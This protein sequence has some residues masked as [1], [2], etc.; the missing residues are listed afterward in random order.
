MGELLYRVSGPDDL[1]SLTMPELAELASEIREKIISVVSSTGG[2]LAPSLGAVELAIAIH[3]V[4]DSPRDRI[5]W[6]VGHQAYA[7]KLLTGRRERFQTLRQEG[8]LSGFPRLSESEHDAFGTGH[9]STSISAALGMSCARDAMGEDFHVVAVIGDGAL[10]GGLSFEGLNQAGGLG[11]RLIV[12]INDNKMSIS[13]NVGALAKYMTRLIAGPTYRK[14]EA[15]LWELLGRT[16]Y[17]GRTAR[18]V[19]GRVTESLKGFIVP[20]TIFEELGFKYYGPIDGHALPDLISVLKQ[21][22][23]VRVPV[24][25]H[26]L[27]T[28][29]KGYRFAEQN[30]SQFHG[31]GA[32]DK[33]TGTEEKKPGFP[34]YTD[35]FGSWMV[36][37]GERFGSVVAVTAAMKDNTGLARFAERFP[38]RFFDV[39]MAEGH[40]VTFAAGLATRGLLPVVAIYSTFLQRAFDH[41]VHDVAL[42]KLKV[43]FA[44]DRAGL[45][46]QDG[47]THHGCLDLVYL[48]AVPG[49]T[50]MA[51]VN[52]RELR[53]ML[54]TAVES[55]SGPV[56]IRFPRSEGT[57]CHVGEAMAAVPVGRAEIL[58]E[59]KDVALC[60][61][62]SM[63]N[64]SLEAA[65]LLAERGVEATVVNARF[66]KPLDAGT[67][68][69]VAAECGKI[70]TV[71]EGTLA[72]GFGSGV[73]ESLTPGRVCPKALRLGI[74]DA[75]VEHASRPALL[76][77]LGL[78]PEGIAGAVLSWLEADR[79]K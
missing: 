59:G 62:G 67:I 57:G 40:A 12:I 74:P 45:V 31:I 7:H 46:G 22:K 32:F 8:G 47:P 66:A 30:S 55:C 25:L 28:K 4:F 68:G 76:R 29:G 6:D 23:E 63:V 70:V 38:G 73:L 21:L 65:G 20:G 41:L 49:L 53:D 64:P 2:H 15:D 9:G 48:R 24:I 50:V 58:R 27:T 3:Y 19:A 39:G 17:V 5:V 79:D 72:G 69:R 78:T 56:A 14:F 1:K 11:K 61:I 44:V 71:E 10:S 35:V 37:I 26:T 34:T 51:P 43:V 75:F 13:P 52:E 16:P 77:R 54:Y 33:V 60:A 36:E 18:Y 42:Q